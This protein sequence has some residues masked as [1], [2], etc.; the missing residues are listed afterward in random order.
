MRPALRQARSLLSC[1]PRTALI[2]AW[3]CPALVRASDSCS[4]L[5]GHAQTLS[6]PR[7]FATSGRARQ[8]FPSTDT[9]ARSE[10]LTQRSLPRACPG[11]GAPAQ[12]FDKNEAGY[13]NVDRK[14]VQAYLRPGLAKVQQATPEDHVYTNALQ[15]ASP[16]LLSQLGLADDKSQDTSSEQAPPQDQSTALTP[17]CDRCHNL[18]HHQSGTPIP[19]PTIDSI[20]EIMR[21]SP[22]RRNHVYHVIDAADFPLSLIPNL[23]AALGIPKLRTQNRRAHHKGWVAND[24]FADMSFIITRSDLLAPTKERVDAMM[25]Y[26]RNVL[27][28]ALGRPNYKARLGNIRLVSAQRGWWTREVKEEIWDRGAAGWMVGKVNV[29]K[30]NLFEA[31]FP[32]GRGADYP[33]LRKYRTRDERV[34]LL[35]KPTSM[36]E[37]VDALTELDREDDS[38]DFRDI[39][40]HERTQKALHPD[41]VPDYDNPDKLLPPPQPYTPYPVFPIASSLPGTTASPIRIPF[42]DR[43]ELIDLPGLPRSTP[44]LE[45]F[46][47]PTEHDSLIM[48]HRINSPRYSLKPGQSLILG[49]GLIRITPQSEDLVFLVY[50]FVPLHAHV[51]R[52]EKAIGYQQQTSERQLPV[53]SVLAPNVGSQMKSA[54]TFKLKWDRTRQLAGP[55]T[56]TMA[57]KM[58]PENLP[59]RIWSTDILIEG[60]GWVEISAQ[61][62]RPQGWSAPGIVKKDPTYTRNDRSFSEILAK[63]HKQRHRDIMAHAESEDRDVEDYMQKRPYEDYIGDERDVWQDDYPAVEVFSPLGK[64]VGARAPMCA[65]LVNGPKVLSSRDRKARPRRSMVTVKRQRKPL[66][67]NK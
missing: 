49:G 21:E 61:T 28:V 51:T 42:G 14:V 46:V 55:V 2:P 33:D 34:D 39:R 36:D 63:E 16:E 4:N 13:Y 23:Q 3:L 58:R 32:K 56:S 64:Y 25:P 43:G 59:Y 11:C 15:D 30:S 31:V 53:P 18:I 37:L 47:L 29:G 50:P 19:H 17:I 20:R 8:A 26:I 27:R 52:T 45:N 1:E 60:V 12:V 24:R 5:H 38:R 22:H 35:N 9:P 6:L 41:P 62:R 40:D 10:P 48:K 65:S 67:K 57:G 7:T 66:D 54:G 44:G